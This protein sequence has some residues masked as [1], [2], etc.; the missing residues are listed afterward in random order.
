MFVDALFPLEIAFGAVGGP[1]F[2]TAINPGL[3]GDEARMGLWAEELGR[4]EVGLIN[5]D[6][7]QTLALIAFFTTVAKGKAN[8]FRFRDF[9]PGENQGMNEPIGV[10]DGATTVF[11]LLKGYAA[12]EQVYNKRI[13]LP[14]DGT[15]QVMLDGIPDDGVTVDVASGTVTFDVAPPDGAVITASFGFDRAVRFDVDWLQIRRI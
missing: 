4:W 10:G 6:A 7:D 5:K 2:L 12:G 13:F 11:Q 14:V 9:Q 3:A 1:G 8:S 15:V